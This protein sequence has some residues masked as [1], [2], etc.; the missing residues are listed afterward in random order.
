MS[1]DFTIGL[2][3]TGD[4]NACLY[5]YFCPCCALA[6][7][8]AHLDGSQYWFNFFCLPLAPYRWLVRSAYNIGDLDS[9]LTDIALTC[10]IPCCVINQLYQ[11]TLNKRN[12]T[13]T[14]GITHNTNDFIASTDRNCDECLWGCCFQPCSVGNAVNHSIGK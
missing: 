8:R 14:G 1:E 2:C 7:S 11:T 12:P 4:Q 3:E 5:S 10:T 13:T 9:G 6:E